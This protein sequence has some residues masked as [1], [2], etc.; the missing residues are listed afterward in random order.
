MSLEAFES[1]SNLNT[2]ISNSK[3]LTSFK[4]FPSAVESYVPIS[5]HIKMFEYQVKDFHL[6]QRSWQAIEKE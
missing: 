6:I 1:Q 3:E 4:T 5:Y 2:S